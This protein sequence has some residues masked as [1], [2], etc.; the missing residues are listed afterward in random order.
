MGPVPDTEAPACRRPLEL[1]TNERLATRP[2][3]TDPGQDK[4]Q[5]AVVTRRLHS[6]PTL[7]TGVGALQTAFE[8]G[9]IRVPLLEVMV[10]GDRKEREVGPEVAIDHLLPRSEIGTTTSGTC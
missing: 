2:S 1:R 6:K 10:A 9:P 7:T 3:A 4:E 8:T 5:P